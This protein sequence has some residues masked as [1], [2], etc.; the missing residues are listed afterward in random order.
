MATAETMLDRP[1]L[2]QARRRLPWVAFAA[3][4]GV[5]IAAYYRRLWVL[6]L[7]GPS[8]WVPDGGWY[9]VAPTLAAWGLALAVALLLLLALLARTPP[10]GALGDARLRRLKRLMPLALLVPA[11]LLA[12]AWPRRVNGQLFPWLG[13]AASRNLWAL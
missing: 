1:I 9:A 8:A 10:P 7:A 12:L 6:A 4:V 3:W 11:A 13:E 2:G 5:V